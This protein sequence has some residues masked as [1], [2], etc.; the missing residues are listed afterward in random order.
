[1]N[2]CLL[3]VSV[4]LT[5]SCLQSL[6]W[7]V[8]VSHW[9]NWAGAKRELPVTPC[10][11]SLFFLS[12]LEEFQG[13][14]GAGVRLQRFNFS[15]MNFFSVV[16]TLNIRV[17]GLDTCTRQKCHFHQFNVHFIVSDRLPLHLLRNIA[18]VKW[19]LVVELKCRH[20]NGSLRELITSGC[21]EKW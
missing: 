2:M 6:I 20:E 17:P 16:L 9:G 7:E 5:A 3:P 14:W 21:E 1:M 13:G 4:F 15:K 19:I 11:F 10:W 18:N 12:P 8:L